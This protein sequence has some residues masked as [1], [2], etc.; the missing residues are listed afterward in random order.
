MGTVYSDHTVRGVPYYRIQSESESSQST[1]AAPGGGWALG[2]LTP[3]PPRL[4]FC[5]CQ[6]R[7]ID[8]I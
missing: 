5:A 1:G 4:F 2:G 6:Y 8:S 3:P 7:P